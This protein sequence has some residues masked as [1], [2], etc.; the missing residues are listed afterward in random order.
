MW[1]EDLGLVLV[2]EGGREE[3]RIVFTL[4]LT[5]CDTIRKRSHFH[6]AS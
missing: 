3:G 5:E 6:T 4:E 1:T 2:K